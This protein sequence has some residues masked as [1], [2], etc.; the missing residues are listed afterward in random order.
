MR[1]EDLTGDPLGTLRSIYEHLRFDGFEA[2]KSQIAGRL[3]RHRSYQKNRYQIDQQT[4]EAV[5]AACQPAFRRY[6]YD[7]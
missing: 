4:R 5:Y 7:R 2:M 3:A 6:G 1:F